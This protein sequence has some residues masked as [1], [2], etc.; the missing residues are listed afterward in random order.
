MQEIDRS[1]ALVRQQILASRQE[2]GPLQ[3]EY[4]ESSSDESGR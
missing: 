4:S 2:K 1:N 3:G